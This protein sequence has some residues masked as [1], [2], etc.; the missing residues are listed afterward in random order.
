MV[1][2]S[3]KCIIVSAP[4]GAGKTTIVRHLLARIP[5]LAFS[6]SATSRPRRVQEVD[7]RDYHFLSADGFRQRIVDGGFLEWEEVYPG[8]FYGTLLSEVE[9]IQGGGGVPIFDVDVVGGLHIKGVFASSALALFIA[10]PTI[11]HLALR[12]RARG[13]ETEETLKARVDKAAH[14]MTYAERF[15]AVIINDTLEH[16][17]QEALERV[18]AFLNTP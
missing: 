14:E 5:R 12:L 11:D 17:C 15:D 6:I 4:A 13:T 16:A 18:T 3:G 2:G 10:P 8:R 9:R 7:G 1:P